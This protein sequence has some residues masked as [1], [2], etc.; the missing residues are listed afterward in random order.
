MKRRGDRRGGRER[1]N[2][3]LG[4]RGREI[5]DKFK[6]KG[7]GETKPRMVPKTGSKKCCIRGRDWCHRRRRRRRGRI[8]LKGKDGRKNKK[9]KV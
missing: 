3:A 5:K 6:G 4:G 1:K 7:E 9:K 2:R 8:R